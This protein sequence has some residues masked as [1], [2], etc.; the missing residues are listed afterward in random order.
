MVSDLKK[1]LL[2]VRILVHQEYQRMSDQRP[3]GGQAK[4]REVLSLQSKRQRLISL[5]VRDLSSG[6]CGDVLE[7]K[8]KRSLTQASPSLRVTRE[9]LVIG[10]IFVFL[11]NLGMLLYVY[12]FAMTQ[13]PSRQSAWFQ[14][15][16]MWLVFEIFVSS[17]GLVIFFHLLFHSM[18]SQRSPRS[19]R[20]CCQI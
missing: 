18:S 6:I 14:S 8:A 19:K 4:D 11:L 17:T 20:R 10:W 9:S 2:R 16:V 3:E 5:F 12:L 15:F 7:N 1:E 13:S